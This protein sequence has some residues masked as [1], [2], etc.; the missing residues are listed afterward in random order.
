MK[1]S[2]HIIV[3]NYYADNHT[4]MSKIINQFVVDTNMKV[5][6]ELIEMGFTTKKQ[7]TKLNYF[8]EL[9]DKS[10]YKSNQQF[11]CINQGKYNT[12]MKQYSK[13]QE[14][15]EDDIVNHHFVCEPFLEDDE[16]INVNTI[17][18]NHHIQEPFNEQNKKDVEYNGYFNYNMLIP[19][20]LDQSKI[21]NIK[22]E[23][24]LPID[25]LILIPNLPR[26]EVGELHHDVIHTICLWVN[27]N[28]ITFELFWN[29]CKQKDE[30]NTYFNRMKIDYD[31]ANKYPL[32]NDKSIDVILGKYYPRITLQTRYSDFEQS[33]DLSD[34]QPEHFIN[35]NRDLQSSDLESDCKYILQCVAMAGPSNI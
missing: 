31:N 22:Y 4:E 25:K 24:L 27:S 26:G 33:F 20:E 15:L 34:I 16:M 1:I 5:S 6:N 10:I 28:K 30:S 17:T 3:W 9:F 8:I 23:D 11:K 12:K 18:L 21:K 19:I 29:W 35:I 7:T 32:V 2:F 13:P 14:I